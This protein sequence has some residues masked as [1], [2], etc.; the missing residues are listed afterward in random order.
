[1][2]WLFD[3]VSCHTSTVVGQSKTYEYPYCV[4]SRCVA[5]FGTDGVVYYVR[6]TAEAVLSSASCSHQCPEIYGDAAGTAV[7]FVTL[8]VVMIDGLFVD[9]AGTMHMS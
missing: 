7:I 1:M 6:A 3:A 2:W 4:S 9:L 5:E 8:P